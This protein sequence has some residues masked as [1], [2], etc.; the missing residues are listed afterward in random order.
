MVGHKANVHMWALRHSLPLRRVVEYAE[1]HATAPRVVQQ[2]YQKND[3]ARSDRRQER[4][5]ERRDG[6]PSRR[7]EDDDA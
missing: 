2:V 6:T 5:E 1:S 4:N 3:R 7:R